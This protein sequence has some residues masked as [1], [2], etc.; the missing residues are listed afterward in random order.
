M[1]AG[2]QDY[3]VASAPHRARG[4]QIR[5]LVHDVLRDEGIAVHS[6]TH[7]VKMEE[8]ARAKIERRPDAYGAFSDLH[9]LLGVRVITHLVT[10][11][12]A[13]VA[14]LR[15]QFDV[16]PDRSLDKVSDLHDDEFGYRS[17]HLVVKL[18]DDRAQLPEWR[19]LAGVYFEIQVRSI[20]RHAWAEIEHDLGYKSSVGVPREIRRRFARMAGLLELADDEFDKLA[21]DAKRHVR[22]T[23]VAIKRGRNVEVDRDSIISLLTTGKA[24]RAADRAI[25]RGTDR[26]LLGVASSKYASLRAKEMR[27]VGLKSS[28][29]VNE[30]MIRLADRV[31]EF[32][33]T[34]MQRETDGPGGDM[35]PLSPGISLFYLYLH[36]LLIQEGDEF[37]SVPSRPGESGLKSNQHTRRIAEFRRIHDSI[38]NSP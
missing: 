9:D 28:R 4:E 19:I 2:N 10:E 3:R 15:H 38:F 27:E 1:T 36:R 5:A 23:N 11:V 7:R 29:A 30:E 33:V 25:A 13:A 34:W 31:A 16:D 12:D 35:T 20:L 22:R 21:R 26:E 14:A 8:S 24:V 17:F 32:A 18:K 6:V 37:D